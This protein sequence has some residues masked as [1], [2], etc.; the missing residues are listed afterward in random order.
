MLGTGETAHVRADLGDED[1]GRP[2]PDPGDRVQ[3]GNGLLLRR[4]PLVNFPTDALD[5]LVQVLQRA[6]V[7]GQQEA[8][9]GRH[10]PL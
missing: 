5:G 9:V 7:L 10:A 2:L 8:M 6:Q 1:L 4:Q 3:E